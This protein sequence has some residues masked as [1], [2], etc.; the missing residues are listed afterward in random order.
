MQ[1]IIM[2]VG[3][4]SSQVAWSDNVNRDIGVSPLTTYVCRLLPCRAELVK[5]PSREYLGN[6]RFSEYDSFLHVT[7]TPTDKAAAPISTG[8]R[9]LG[10]RAR[11]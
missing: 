9:A 5:G 6:G 4:P 10:V 8:K 1:L 2:V 3:Q 11:V 7:F